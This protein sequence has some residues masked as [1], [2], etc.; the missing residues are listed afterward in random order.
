MP[1]FSKCN[2]SLYIYIDEVRIDIYVK[3]P[4]TFGRVGTELNRTLQAYVHTTPRSRAA[5]E[6]DVRGF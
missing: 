1:H 6:C 3:K 5:K 2:S 4:T